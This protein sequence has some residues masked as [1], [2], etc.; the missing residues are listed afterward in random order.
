MANEAFETWVERWLARERNRC[1]MVRVLGARGDLDSAAALVNE[2]DAELQAAIAD[3]IVRPCGG[4]LGSGSREIETM[5]FTSETGFC[6][7]PTATVRRTVQ[8]LDCAGVGL[9]PGASRERVKAER[10]RKAAT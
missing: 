7:P 6:E 4:C 5:V 9:V 8:C 10:D 3:G 2:S 1:A